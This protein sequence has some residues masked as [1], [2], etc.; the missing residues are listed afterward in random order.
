MCEHDYQIVLMS[1]VYPKFVIAE[2][3][4]CKDEFVQ[5]S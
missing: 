3:R 1:E 4:I 2:C 5:V